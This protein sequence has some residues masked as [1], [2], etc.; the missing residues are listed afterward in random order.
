MSESK[1][2][3]QRNV[4]RG[5]TYDERWDVGGQLAANALRFAMNS[6]E[7]AYLFSPTRALMKA[8]VLPK[9]GQGP[10]PKQQR[11]GKF[12]IHFYGTTPSGKKLAL[13]VSGDR[14]PGY[15]GTSRMIGEVAVCLLKDQPKDQLAGGF[16]TPA[17]AIAEHLIPR[18]EQ[19][20]GMTFKPLEL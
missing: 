15:S 8:A 4:P 12:K 19:N 11:A 3:Q 16:W 2:S 5:F 6:V 1:W 20:A 13:A 17:A 9:P 14:D 7:N 18:L 10:T